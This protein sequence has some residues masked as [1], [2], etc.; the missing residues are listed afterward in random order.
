MA[1]AQFEYARGR[2]TM[3]QKLKTDSI[4]DP[5]QIL[6]V[7]RWLDTIGKNLTCPLCKENAEWMSADRFM[8]LVTSTPEFIIIT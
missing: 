3:V 8:S 4:N 2:R 6:R 7:T 5:D 1:V